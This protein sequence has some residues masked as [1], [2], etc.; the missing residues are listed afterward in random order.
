MADLVLLDVMMPGM[1]GDRVRRSAAE[2]T[3]SGEDHFYFRISGHLAS[4][5]TRGA[6]GPRKNAVKNG[7]EAIYLGTTFADSKTD[8]WT[9]QWSRESVILTSC[10]S[11]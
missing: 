10:F 4:R 8:H 7:P 9:R 2:D 5:Q 11:F 1:T 6:F 3:P